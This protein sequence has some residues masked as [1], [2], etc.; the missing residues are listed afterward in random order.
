MTKVVRDFIPARTINP[1]DSYREK[2]GEA[3]AVY[4]GEVRSIV[5]RLMTEYAH[6]FQGALQ[7]TQGPSSAAEMQPEFRRK[8]FLHHLNVSGVYYEFKE[9][10]KTSVVGVVREVRGG[11]CVC[12]AVLGLSA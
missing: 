3:D 9:R 12:C 7:A 1:D 5:Y 8:R 4:K 11:A 6:V 2:S 10:L